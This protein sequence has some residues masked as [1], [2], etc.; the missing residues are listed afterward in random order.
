MLGQAEG[1]V[2]AGV[3]VCV[4]LGQVVP[5]MLQSLWHFVDEEC[6]TLYETGFVQSCRAEREACQCDKLRWAV[7][8]IHDAISVFLTVAC[9]CLVSL[10]CHPP[11]QTRPREQDRHN[12]QVVV[13]HWH[14]DQQTS[15]RTSKYVCTNDDDSRDRPAEE[16]LARAADATVEEVEGRKTMVPGFNSGAMPSF[17]G[18][19]TM[20]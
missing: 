15:K 1:K 10:A 11:A 5:L 19:C 7:H 12:T 3:C 18:V 6:Q 17:A 8:A 13:T 16:M 9:H 2:G 20:R 4:S 14:I